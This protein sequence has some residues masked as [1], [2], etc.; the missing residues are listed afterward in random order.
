MGTNG[1]KKIAWGQNQFVPIF[2]ENFWWGQ[3]W[4]QNQIGLQPN[5]H[6]GGD[7]RGQKGTKGDK[8]PLARRRAR[9]GQVGN[10][11]SIQ[12]IPTCP[13]SFEARFWIF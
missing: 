2:F 8:C 1:D 4:G 7:K 6:A 11:P 3:I 5:K 13:H 9:W 12:G 10:T